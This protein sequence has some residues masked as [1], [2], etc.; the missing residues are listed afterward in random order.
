MTGFDQ[1]SDPER[2]TDVCDAAERK[3]A[4]RC[5]FCGALRI[6]L[7]ASNELCV[8]CVQVI[9]DGSLQPFEHLQKSQVPGVV[10]HAPIGWRE[11]LVPLVDGSSVDDSDLKLVE[12][13]AADGAQI[14]GVAVNHGVVKIQVL[15]ARHAR[16]VDGHSIM[17]LE[18]V[19]LHDHRTFVLPVIEV[20]QSRKQGYTVL[21]SR[22][23]VVGTTVLS[24]LR[25]DNVAWRLISPD[26]LS[27]LRRET[28]AIGRSVSWIQSI[29]LR[30]ELIRRAQRF[31]WLSGRG[32]RIR[33][34]SGSLLRLCSVVKT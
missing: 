3:G 30:A 32:L 4:E 33:G 8:A 12:N 20:V 17:V 7:S 5:S 9:V 10:G 11:R 34:G 13:F 24:Q 28:R 1:L 16:D 6:I 15:V 31:F 18:L 22:G 29:R 21:T 2:P 27:D 26:T 25:E 14:A 19:T 23:L